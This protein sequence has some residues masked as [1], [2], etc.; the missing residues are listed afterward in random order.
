MVQGCSRDEFEFVGSF[1]S[2]Y[3]FRLSGSL[4]RFAWKLFCG[5][6][7][8]ALYHYLLLCEQLTVHDDSLVDKA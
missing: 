4:V 7:Y 3:V 8:D 2:L 6:P 1:V 5:L